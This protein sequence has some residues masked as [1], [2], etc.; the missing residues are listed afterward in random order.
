MG[1]KNDIQKTYPDHTFGISFL[2]IVSQTFR[3]RALS[4]SMVKCF[5]FIM[6]RGASWENLAK[7]LVTCGRPSMENSSPRF[8][9]FFIF[10]NLAAKPTK[11]NF[12]HDQKPVIVTETIFSCILTL[13]FLLFLNFLFL[14]AQ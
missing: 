10:F 7:I 2:A 9:F 3:L 8:F 1:I 4:C 11:Y 13:T 6:G 12:S 5:F 14:E